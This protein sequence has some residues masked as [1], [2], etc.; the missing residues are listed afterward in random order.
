[1]QELRKVQ[2]VNNKL[3]VNK[4]E[5]VSL[6]NDI[7]NP[8]LRA[9]NRLNVITNLGDTSLGAKYWAALGS[10]AIEEIRK[11]SDVIKKFGTEAVHASISRNVVI[12]EASAA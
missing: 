6:F 12:D 10:E 9:W 5:F 4:N 7:K 2:L 1:M 8:Q 3:K 11:L